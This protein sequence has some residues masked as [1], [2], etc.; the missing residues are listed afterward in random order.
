MP[1]KN[2]KR[3]A[4]EIEQQEEEVFSVEK[5]VCKQVVGGKTQYLLKW[6]GYDSDENTWEPEENLDCQDLLDEFNKR[7]KMREETQAAAANSG[8]ASVS[9]TTASITISAEDKV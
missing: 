2:R 7:T 9:V 3:K 6:K 8:N 4:R 5:I 1:K